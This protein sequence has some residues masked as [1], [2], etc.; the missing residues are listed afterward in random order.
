[1]EVYLHVGLY[2][3][4][5]TEDEH[6]VMM[7]DSTAHKGTSKCHK[8]DKKPLIFGACFSINI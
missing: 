8:R 6:K 5:D 3:N 7:K 2:E 4:V 1:M